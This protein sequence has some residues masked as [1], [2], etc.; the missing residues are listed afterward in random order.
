MPEPNDTLVTEMQKW[1]RNPKLTKAWNIARIAWFLIC[2]IVGTTSGAYT[3]YIA[4]GWFG[5][6][7]AGL[8]GLIIGS[9]FGA[10][11]ELLLMLMSTS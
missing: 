2:V 3:G 5:A 8:L 7:G 1:V 11:P 6:V 9:I 4:Y 10:G